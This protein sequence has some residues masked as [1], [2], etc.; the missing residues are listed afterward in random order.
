MVVSFSLLVSLL[1]VPPFFA[2]LFL[3]LFVSLA[4]V[5][6]GR[7]LPLECSVRRCK[8]LYTGAPNKIVSTRLLTT[9]RSICSAI[10]PVLT[11]ICAQLPASATQPLLLFTSLLRAVFLFF[12]VLSSAH[13][14]PVSATP[15]SQLHR[16]KSRI[17]FPRKYYSI[18]KAWLLNPSAYIYI[19]QLFCHMNLIDIWNF[20][21]LIIY[22]YIYIYILIFLKCNLYLTFILKLVIIDIDNRIIENVRK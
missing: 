9:T 22:S 18:Q 20:Y 16:H 5:F 2:S 15:D 10:L 7:E 6:C 8:Y 1:S 11:R 21:S 13:T 19:V 14:R 4:I 12:T 17:L 3:C